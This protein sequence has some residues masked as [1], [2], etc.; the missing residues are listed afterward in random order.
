MSDAVTNGRFH[1]S[2]REAMRI[3][4]SPGQG[5]GQARYELQPRTSL[6]KGDP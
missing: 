3:S 5:H 2:K 1:L 6:E 4:L